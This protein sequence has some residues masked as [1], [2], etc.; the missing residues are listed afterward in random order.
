MIGKTGIEQL[1]TYF[2]VDFIADLKY[3]KSAIG[4]CT[5]L[6]I[7]ILVYFVVVNWIVSF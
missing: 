3:Q 5:V 1:E 2:I 6:C 7:K 4:L